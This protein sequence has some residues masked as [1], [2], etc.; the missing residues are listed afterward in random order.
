MMVWYWISLP[1]ATFGVA[2]ANGIVTRAAPIAAWSLGKPAKVLRYYRR[3]GA[4]IERL[5]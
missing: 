3:A 5:P 4:R 1:Y 2:I